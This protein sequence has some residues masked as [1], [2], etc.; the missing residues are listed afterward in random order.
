MKMIA[1]GGATVVGASAVISTPAFADG[2]SN[3]ARVS[4]PSPVRGTTSNVTATGFDLEITFPNANCPVGGGAAKR[5]F[6]VVR[7]DSS[8]VGAEVTGPGVGGR[9]TTSGTESFSFVWGTDPNPVVRI[10]I[11]L[12]YT[13]P[14]F[15]TGLVAWACNR[16]AMTATRG[17]SPDFTPTF[18]SEGFTNNPTGWCNDPL[19]TL[20]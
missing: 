16:W 7:V 12:R 11:R 8:T 2:G 1:V 10:G 20:P 9:V 17:A 19:P 6:D 13:C 18:S 14:D 5:E 4:V 3:S 15:Q